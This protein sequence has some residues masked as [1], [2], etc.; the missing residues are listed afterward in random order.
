MG[1]T[2]RRL[3]L[4][5]AP[6]KATDSEENREEPDPEKEKRRPSKGLLFADH[7]HHPEGGEKKSKNGE[8][9]TKA[10]AFTQGGEKVRRVFSY[11]KGGT[12]GRSG[13]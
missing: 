2:A 6:S 11:L 3:P 8:G 7:G 4:G 9:T 5:V 10:L 1:K 13:Q 12:Q